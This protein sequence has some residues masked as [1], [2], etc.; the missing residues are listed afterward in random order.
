MIRFVLMK[1]GEVWFWCM[2]N[3]RTHEHEDRKEH[4]E[5]MKLLREWLE[6]GK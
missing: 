1:G 6:T 3:M 5:T 2:A 4:D